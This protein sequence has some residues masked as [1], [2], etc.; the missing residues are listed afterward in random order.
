MTDPWTE[1]L[2]FWGSL[3]QDMS[4]MRRINSKEEKGGNGGLGRGGRLVVSLSE[5]ARRPGS[6]R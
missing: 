1:R 2:A 4:S 3:F 6:M 5:K